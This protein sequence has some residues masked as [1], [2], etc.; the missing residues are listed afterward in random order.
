MRDL[1]NQFFAALDEYTCSCTV[2][3]TSV[4]PVMP[5]GSGVAVKYGEKEYILT[6]AHVLADKPD[7]TKLRILGRPNHPL[8]MM[9]GKEELTDAIR[10]NVPTRFSSA[11]SCPVIGRLTADTDDIAALEVAKLKA[12]LPHTILHDLLHGGFKFQVQRVND[13]AVAHR[14]PGAWRS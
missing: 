13:G 8:Q 9:R 2:A 10:K 5:H 12:V 11:V 3:I 14:L 4:D 7:N 1:E 6:A